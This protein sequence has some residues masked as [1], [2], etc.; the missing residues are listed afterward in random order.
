MA[1]YV[2]ITGSALFFTAVGRVAASGELPDEVEYEV[3]SE[4]GSTSIL[5]GYTEGDRIIE[6]WSY[7]M[8]TGDYPWPAA[9]S[10]APAVDVDELTHLNNVYLSWKASIYHAKTEQSRN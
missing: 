8:H 7:W 6:T 4:D 9:Y 3:E 10:T 2:S 1:A 5:V